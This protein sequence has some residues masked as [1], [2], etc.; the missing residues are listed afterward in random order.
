MNS[1]VRKRMARMVRRQ[2]GEN[3]GVPKQ[4]EDEEEEGD[5]MVPGM[6]GKEASASDSCDKRAVL[7]LTVGK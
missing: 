3:K 7:A 6:E 1:A 4:P 5:V 2:S